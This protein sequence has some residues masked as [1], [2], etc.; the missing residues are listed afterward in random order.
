[1]DPEVAY[2]LAINGDRQARQNLVVWIRNGGFIP[3][4]LISEGYTSKGAAVLRLMALC[5]K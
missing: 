4:A 2:N 3:Q 5:S 1:M